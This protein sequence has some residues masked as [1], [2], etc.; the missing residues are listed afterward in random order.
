MQTI[1]F[2]CNYFRSTR[3]SV[4]SI[5]NT[6]LSV[7]SIR[8]TGIHSYTFPF[9]DAGKKLQIAAGCRA[10]KAQ[11]EQKLRRKH[12][13]HHRQDSED[14]EA[15]GEFF[16]HIAAEEETEDKGHQS[17]RQR[18]RSR[19]EGRSGESLEVRPDPHRAVGTGAGRVCAG[20]SRADEGVLQSLIFKHLKGNRRLVYGK[21]PS[22]H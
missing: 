8:N 14:A 9:R 17:L 10:G 21:F 3:L 22:D 1:V 20:D 15:D 6:R 5:R 13:R 18:P 11:A 2:I 16:T 19:E 12:G 7:C 4:C